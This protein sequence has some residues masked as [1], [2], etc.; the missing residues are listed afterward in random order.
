MSD[1]LGELF[2]IA[3][4]YGLVYIYTTDKGLYNASITFNTTAHTK[5]EAKSDFKRE[6]P[7]DALVQA[8]EAAQQI[9]DS[10]GKMST[11]L[12]ARKL[13]G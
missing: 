6:S 3:R 9:V 4:Q 12:P 13:L 10:I 5:L 11:S 7:E 1:Q 2:R 8:I